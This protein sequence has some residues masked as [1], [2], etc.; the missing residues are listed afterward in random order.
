GEQAAWCLLGRCDQNANTIPQLNVIDQLRLV[1]VWSST[2][3]IGILRPSRRALRS[4]R[5][6]SASLYGID[7][8]K[9]PCNRRA[10]VA[11]AENPP[12]SPD[13]R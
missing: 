8:L 3:F 12:R 9:T 11:S 2:Q 13:L 7:H 1:N 10:A 4:W 5:G 6:A